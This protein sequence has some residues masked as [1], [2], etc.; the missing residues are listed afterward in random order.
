MS[1][2]IKPYGDTLG[3]GRVQLAFTLPVSNSAKA[4]KAAEL[5][6]E[7]LNLTD[8]SICFAEEIGDNFTYFV[9]YASAVPELDYST[10]KATEIT[11]AELDFYQINELI[12]EKINKKLVVVG[13]SIG[14]D[15]HTVGIDA[16]MNM[17]GYNHDYGLERYPEI[18]AF[19]LGAQVSCEE[20]MNAAVERNADAILV[21]QTITQKNAHIQNFT[22]LAELLE[23]EDLRHRFL[24][25]AGGPRITHD[26]AIELGYDAGFGPGTLA[27]QVAAYIASTLAA[28][29]TGEDIRMHEV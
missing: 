3:D 15:A 22:E 10:V 16:I 17:K 23:A 6:A 27:S 12:R 9:I 7:R 2:M 24:L 4:R 20:L 25:I 21:S 11:V 28:L 26:L 18:S 8:V 13:A 5:Y 1:E 14:S 19:N 29:K